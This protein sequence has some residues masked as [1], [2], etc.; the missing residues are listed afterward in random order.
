[1]EPSGLLPRT[2]KSAQ[3]RP[4]EAAAELDLSRYGVVAGGRT[5]ALVGADGSIGWMCL[6]RFDSPSVIAAILDPGSGGRCRLGPAARVLGSQRYRAGTNVLVTRFDLPDG[7][8]EITDWMPARFDGAQAEE[9]GQGSLCRLVSVL[10]GEVEL[11]FECEPRFDYGREPA[12]WER[13]GHAGCWKAQDG[14]PLWI[15]SDAPLQHDDHASPA[16]TSRFVLRRGETRFFAMVWGTRQCLQIS[17]ERIEASLRETIQ[18]WRRW[19]KQ[20]KYDG[21]YRDA[22][23]RSALTLKALV[24]DSTGAMVAAPTTSLPEAIGGPR[25]WDYRYCWP[26][27]ATFALYGL[28][29]LGYHEEAG[30][31]LEFIAHLAETKPLPLQV[32]YRVD[33]DTDLEER[34]LPWL[35]GYRGSR[36]VRV[37]NGAIQQRQLDIYG[38]VLDAAYTYAKWREGLSPQLWTA[39]RRLVEYAAQHWSEPDESIWEVRGGPRHFLYS[40]VM[41]WVAMDRAVR[42]CTKYRLPGPVD[43]WAALRDHI[44]A[45]IVANGY[46]Q[47][48]HAYTQSFGSDV[49]DASALL[50]PLVRFT[51]P[52]EP[53]M[54]ST[55]R[56]IQQKLGRGTLV[57]RYENTDADGVGGP[58]GSFSICTFW[59]IDCLTL[60][61]RTDESRDLFERMLTLGSPLGLY[62]EEIDA[63]TG[64]MLGNL[65]QAFT[66]MALINSAHNLELYP[67]GVPLAGHHLHE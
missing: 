65:P 59:L 67:K 2:P 21:P 55:I 62:S 27:D 4:P 12:K 14:E 37:G 53:R 64:T 11:E 31:F 54:E 61:G 44:R 51:H 10:D 40:K 24:Y 15:H 41:C 46:H 28:S 8:M 45:T 23:L 26:R 66:H 57:A 30:R 18:V 35:R 7:K 33:G 9:F 58:E 19:A 50:M 38:E 17:R 22:V 6:P 60:L 1:M 34:E 5:M 48:V 47:G 3:A 39:M 13:S 16:L 49:L 43:Q 20:A 29:L 36:P 42:L 52:R 25:N 32:C 56:V 63:S